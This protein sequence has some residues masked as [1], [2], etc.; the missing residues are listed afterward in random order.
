[1][2]QSPGSLRLP[3]EP[4]DLFDLFVPEGVVFRDDLDGDRPIHGELLAFEDDALCTPA[5][6]VQELKVADALASLD[7]RHA[8]GAGVIGGVGGL[9][10]H[11]LVRSLMSQLS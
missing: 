1:M 2:A 9:R 10:G 5:D 11:S 3:V 4:F 8:K 7:R 6:L